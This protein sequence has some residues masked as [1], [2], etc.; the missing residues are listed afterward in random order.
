MR[1][2]FRVRSEQCEVRFMPR[3]GK[4]EVGL[5]IKVREVVFTFIS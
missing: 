3:N 4:G 5:K 1:V 2:S